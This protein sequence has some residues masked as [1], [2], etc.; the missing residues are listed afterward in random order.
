MMRRYPAGVSVLTVDAEGDRLGVT[1]ASLV[2]LSLQPPLV[3]VSLGRDLAVHA[4]V[5]HAGG[6]AVSILSADQEQL[7]RHFAL[8]VPPIALW[9]GVDVR[10]GR[11]APLL[12]GALGW[13]ECLVA[14]E[15]D[16]GD[17]TFFVGDVIAAEAGSAGHG[18]VYRDSGYHPA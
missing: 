6:F 4:L 13:L 12:D 3:G 5:R 15:H 2:S 1:L 18:L 17:H 11:V 16:A 9:E 7:A 8:G 10:D 14:A